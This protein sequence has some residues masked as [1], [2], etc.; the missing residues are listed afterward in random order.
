MRNFFP[1]TVLFILLFSCNTIKNVV[2]KQTDSQ[3]FFG[4]SGGF[5]NLKLEYVLND[6]GN[7][8]KIEKDSVLYIKKIDSSQL[9]N[10]RHL[11]DKYEFRNIK[12]NSP[13]NLSYFIRVKTKK[14]QNEVVWSDMSS[15]GPVDTIYN[16]LF[17]SLK[18]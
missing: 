4:N 16:K 18:E 12:L 10:I 5:T 7:I 13:G 6:D 1:V 3:I 2:Y 11:I 8:F 15:K 17:D 9:K 14:F